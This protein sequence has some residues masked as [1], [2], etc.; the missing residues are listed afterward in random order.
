MKS[1]FE[2]QILGSL[3]LIGLAI[4]SISPNDYLTWVLEVFPILLG[5]PILIVTYKWFHF[6]QAA[7][8]LMFIHAIILM[9]GGHYTY[10]QVPF[11]F[12]MQEV[13]DFSRNHYDRIGHFAQGLVPAFLA[14]EVLIRTS[15]L[16]RGGWVRFLP[17]AVA[18]FISALYEIIEW[19]SA[20]ILG[21]SADAF[22]GSQG[23]IWD[24]QWDMAMAL[25]GSS[26]TVILPL[27]WHK[28][29]EEN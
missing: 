10:A 9:I 21:S 4:S 18:M 5:V 1:K 25:I 26:L 29:E 12:W 20:V 23:D 19:Q 13:F 11:G 2:P 7:Y 14:R 16:K 24:T 3:C 17:V 27:G 28:V 22:L 6:S 15:P 8:R